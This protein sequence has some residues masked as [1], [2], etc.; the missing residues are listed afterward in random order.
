MLQLHDYQKKAVEHCLREK[1]VFL[2]MDLGLGKTIVSM[3]VM[4]E[5][6]Q[7]AIVFGNI[8]AIY[9][10]WPKEIK[11]W[12]PWFTYDIL[13]G[14]N[15]TSTFLRS[16]A[17]Y[18]LIN[19]DGIKWFFKLVMERRI[20]WKKRMLILDESSLIK[21]PDTIRFKTLRKMMPLWSDYR[22]C[23][24]ATPA[25]KGYHNLWS[26]Y[27]M[28]DRGKR[29]FDS[30]YRYRGAYFNYT[31]PPLYKT[32]LRKGS[33]EAIRDTIKDITYRLEGDDWL[34]LP[35]FIYNNIPVKL[36]PRLRAQYKELEDNFFIEF[37]EAGA[38][39]FSAAALSMKLRQFIQGAVYT[40]QK[41]GSFYPLH[42][43]K[44]EAL[45]SLLESSAGQPI[46]CPIQF[47]FE[48]KMIKE[49]V[50]KNVPCIAGGTKTSERRAYIDGWNR[51]EIPLLLCHPRSL[52]KSVNL[53]AGGHIL[54]W[55][56]LTWSLEDYQQLNGR[57]R[58]Q[59]QESDHVIVNH[60]MMED[61]VDERVADVLASDNATQKKL[62]DALKR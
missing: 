53:Q 3:T 50:D 36:P 17:D 35:R 49:F 18:L 6:K 9:D 42:Q 21:A 26:Q 10:T 40:D 4:K 22:L 2:A 20:K 16:N 1:T 56:A 24:S 11:K 61:T 59:G 7:P 28:L 13:H 12:Y 62:L 60:L 43:I 15:K 34:D 31:G 55:F 48:L 32:T 33:F 46:L 29:L 38:T 19:Y 25:P 5:I 58:R 27:Y 54:L 44:I 30:Y 41:D 47:K 39:A 57:L 52:S 23:L 8:D 14:P 45:K 37:E 51:G